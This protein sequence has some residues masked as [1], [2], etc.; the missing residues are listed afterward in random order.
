M[1]TILIVAALCIDLG[2][3]WSNSPRDLSRCVIIMGSPA[4]ENLC[5][6]G[7]GTQNPGLDRTN[8][9]NF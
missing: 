8:E 4:A 7:S 2:D 9:P 3:L 5:F 1:H 6:V